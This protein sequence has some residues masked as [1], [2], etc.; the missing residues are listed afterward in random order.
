MI[1]LF[2]RW[3]SGGRHRASKPVC[4]L[5]VEPHFQ[6]RS[7]V[8]WAMLS[9]FGSRCPRLS[10][11]RSISRPASKGIESFL[12][13]DAGYQLPTST[14]VLIPLLCRKR[15]SRRTTLAAGSPAIEPGL[16]S[17]PSSTTR[18][19]P[20]SL[21]KLQEWLGHSFP[22]STR[23]F[24]MFVSDWG[25]SH[26]GYQ[27]GMTAGVYS[28]DAQLYEARVVLPLVFVASLGFVSLID[29]GTDGRGGRS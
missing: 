22:E 21:F 2:F 29:A 11:S 14:K 1:P 19:E 9:S 16:P 18:K 3:N 17:L 13:G 10:H 6:T 7:M 25:I 28:W 26:F 27:C 4:F 15:L 8:W 5:H 20:L 12:T 24:G 23:H